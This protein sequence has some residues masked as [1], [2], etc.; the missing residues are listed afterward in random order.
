MNATN[1]KRDY[2]EVLDIAPEASADEIKRAY[3][4]K[5]MELH[6]DRHGGSREAEENF[7]ELTEAYAVLS[8]P[9]RKAQ[10]DGVRGAGMG[11]DFDP[12]SALGDLFDNEEFARM[13]QEISR[14]MAQQGVHLDDA[15]LRRAFGGKGVFFGGGFVFGPGMGAAG[16]GGPL[17]SILKMMLGLGEPPQQAKPAE[18]DHPRELPPRKQ[19][20]FDKLFGCAPLSLGGSKPGDFTFTLPVGQDVLLL[21]GPVTVK[22]PRGDTNETL[23]VTV[24]PGTEP[25]TKL[26][27]PGKGKNA[28]GKKGDLYLEVVEKP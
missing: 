24:P 14:Q 17:F 16:P 3:R 8:D 4:A 13:F 26:R 2:Y 5:A 15:F 25:G 19:G 21:G 6:P 23:R 20:L 28:G 11:A 12:D 18:R 22:L 7:K 10:Y 27:L 1:G 9:H